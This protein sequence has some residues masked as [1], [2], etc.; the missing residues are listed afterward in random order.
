MIEYGKIFDELH[1]IVFAKSKTLNI[2]SKISDNVFVYPTNSLSKIF[3]IL[4]A[5]RIAKRIIFK[6]SEKGGFVHYGPNAISDI[7]ITA[8]DPF[9]TGFA[10]F[11]IKFRF[12]LPLQVQIHTD[13]L[14]PYFRIYIKNRIRILISKFIIP[15]ADGIRVVSER[16]KTSLISRFNISES[17]I[18]KLPIL[19]DVK[20]YQ[21]AKVKIDLR[22]IYKNYDFIILMAGRLSKEKNIDL[23]MRAMQIVAKKYPKSLLLVVGEGPRKTYLEHL[24][25][26]LG[27]VNNV[28]FEEWSNDLTS[29]YKSADLFLLTS[30]YEG[31]CLSI[32]EAMAAG[33]PI[34][35]TDVGIARELVKDPN[36]DGH[37]AR[38]NGKI[39]PVGDKI[40]LIKAI[41]SLIQ[42]KQLRSKLAANALKTADDLITKRQYLKKYR[43]SLEFTYYNKI[44]KLCYVLPRYEKN[45][46]THFS[47]MHGFLPIISDSFSIHLFIEKGSIPP[48][49]LGYRKA[50][51]LSSS[52]LPLRFIETLSR[53]FFIRLTGTRDFY[54]HYSFLSAFCAGLI[55]KIFGGRIFYW[56]CGEPW[57][58]R[59]NLFRDWF[60]RI[61]Y[62]RVN[63]VTGTNGLKKQYAKHYH[64]PLE[65]IFVMPNWI[66]LSGVKNYKSRIKRNT[67][68]KRLGAKSNDKIILFVHRLSKRK[69]AHYLP[70]ILRN[71]NIITH[72][73]SFIL[74]VIGE[75]PEKEKIE[76]KIKN[77]GLSE[78]V[79]FLGAVP[80]RQLSDYY[81]LAD[82]FIMPSDEEGFPHVLLESMASETPFVATD[83]GGVRDIVPKE[84]YK[85]LVHPGDMESF[86][87]KTKE[88]ASMNK[89]NLAKIK[90]LFKKWIRR[91]DISES[92]RKFRKILS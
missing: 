66:D 73:S 50:S 27:I 67:L 4:D 44:Q 87:K 9:E 92:I 32:V 70:E 33:L 17:R 1:I 16:I 72:N 53:L 68:R 55:V 90:S 12:K 75:G 62:K 63:L 48:A 77:C 49:E 82:V 7:V 81:S 76:L 40:Q 88:L 52:F 60:E 41:E 71:L 86:A 80:N 15:R 61:V 79:R 11:F 91:Y 84:T 78:K 83:V 3:Y 20:K 28:K 51:I 14:S 69:G 6:L 59:R 35:M 30:N 24:M 54:I 37:G 19:I 38:I 8:Q 18:Y 65:R 43:E 34:V 47:S 45:D 31:Y 10:G 2:K 29:Y 57:K 56:N 25:R 89:K 39:V 22:Q 21:N 42:D 85:F 5:C 64:I 74:L 46:A 58:Y 26:H 13:F 23:A 36:L